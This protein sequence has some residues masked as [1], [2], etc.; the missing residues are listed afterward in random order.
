[1]DARTVGVYVHVPFCAAK[2][3][4]CSFNS[5][6]A[7]EGEIDR[8][9]AALRREMELRLDPGTVTDT[10]YFGGGTPTMLDPSQLAGLVRALCE[11]VSIADGAEVT[12]EANP[13]SL[14]RDHLARLPEAGFNR[15]SLGVQSFDDAILATLGRNHD[16]ARAVKAI[17]DMRAAGWNNVS[18]DLI[19]GVPGQSVAQWETTLRRAL[20]MR[21]EHISTYCLTVEAPSEFHR[22]RLAGETMG[23]GEEIEL[24]MLALGGSVLATAGYERY[25]ISN[26]ALR[27]RRCR[28]NEKYWRADDWVG[29]G[30][31]AH[32]SS[33]GI[34]WANAAAPDR[35]VEMLRR[36]VL[37]VV[38]AERLAARR[39]MD[40]G[41]ILAL[42]TVEGADLASLS[43]HYGRD[44]EGEYRTI[45]YE[46]ARAGLAVVDGPRVSLTEEG[47]ALASEVAVRVMA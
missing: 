3:P 2:C 16:A 17:E 29:L 37:P 9:L 47:M 31:G 33:G 6:P 36:G 15:L 8:Y 38:Y 32:S 18:L 41:L 24:E 39:R 42:R 27:A 19:F 5:R 45:V 43:A 21:P 26:F 30:A 10:I 34:R 12:L 14:T 22:R 40:E 13:D 25:E 1:M 20:D 46:L 35:Y 23:V 44:A 4:Y 7:T 11:R 28:H